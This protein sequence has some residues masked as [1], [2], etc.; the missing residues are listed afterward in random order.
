V[1][2]LADLFIV[3]DVLLGERDAVRCRRGDG[4][5]IVVMRFEIPFTKYE[6]RGQRLTG[7]GFPLAYVS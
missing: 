6:N 2:F 7:I 1:Q 3:V 4:I 5:D